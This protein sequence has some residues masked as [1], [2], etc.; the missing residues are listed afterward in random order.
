MQL[1]N[2]HR[3]GMQVITKVL[4]RICDVKQMKV[5]GKSKKSNFFVL[6]MEEAKKREELDINHEVQLNLFGDGIV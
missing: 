2:S 3:P 4:D 6:K 5:V 1:V